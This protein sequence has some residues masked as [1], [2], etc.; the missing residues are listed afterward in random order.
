MR[1]IRIL[2]ILRILR[3]I[4]KDIQLKLEV[5]KSIKA[6]LDCRPWA[7]RPNCFRQF[8][9]RH[10]EAF[11]ILQVHF[12]DSNAKQRN[13]IRLKQSKK[14]DVS[15]I[16]TAVQLQ[17]AGGESRKGATGRF[18]LGCTGKTYCKYFW[19]NVNFFSQWVRQ[20]CAFN[21]WLWVHCTLSF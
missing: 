11:F 1:I 12:S 9:T 20:Q 21:M 4:K 8:S 2:R 16:L 5:I 19:A 14:R 10:L 6:K 18:V 15:L 7:R 17:K 13:A 3:I